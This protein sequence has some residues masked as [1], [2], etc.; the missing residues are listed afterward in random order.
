MLPS[1]AWWV[2]SKHLVERKKR[3][4]RAT[5]INFFNYGWK[6]LA[7]KTS[8]MT[9][10]NR[11]PGCGD[12]PTATRIYINIQRSMASVWLGWYERQQGQPH[13]LRVRKRGGWWVDRAW[14]VPDPTPPPLISR[15]L[16]FCLVQKLTYVYF[17][18]DC[19]LEWKYTIIYS[20]GVRLSFETFE[21]DSST[22]YCHNPICKLTIF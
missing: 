1:W 5:N 2:L 17:M 9:T 11:A 15:T 8:V 6:T 21:F 7:V 14:E 3:F 22:E 10:P 18:Q 16:T 20:D 4:T 19:E 13:T 12:V